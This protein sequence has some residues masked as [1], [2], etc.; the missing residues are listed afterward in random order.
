V[1]PSCLTSSII[2][3]PAGSFP[4]RVGCDGLS[5]RRWARN[6]QHAHAYAWTGRGL[7]GAQV[8]STHRAELE[9]L[10]C[11]RPSTTA[12]NLYSLLHS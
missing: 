8:A 12:A 11:Q 3:F 2:P 10:A 9:K 7:A 5:R 6:N 1:S 4:F